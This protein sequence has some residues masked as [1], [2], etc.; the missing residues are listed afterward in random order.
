MQPGKFLILAILG[1]AALVFC[2]VPCCTVKEDRDLCP[3]VLVLETS[4]VAEAV[5]SLCVSISGATELYDVVTAP[6]QDEYR[7]NVA[8]G[9]MGLLVTST[10]TDSGTLTIG[11][12]SECPKLWLW[13][14]VISFYGEK[15]I[16]IPDLHKRFCCLTLTAISSVSPYPYAIAVS[17]NVCGYSS[18]GSPVEGE[19][20]VLKSL[21]SSMSCTICLPQQIDDSLMLDLM[22][23]GG[24]VR[25]FAIGEYI[26]ESGYDWSASDLSDLTLQ[27]DFASTSLTLSYDNWSYV[28]QL[29]HIV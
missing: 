27:I 17:G 26:A 23:E 13:R 19:F 2:L 12:G 6:F 5:D 10:V 8:R 20:Y 1:G 24:S 16:V 22:S 29:K 9:E 11:Y 28:V 4:L 7:Y 18:D 25:S 14:E 3:G 21:S 15:Q